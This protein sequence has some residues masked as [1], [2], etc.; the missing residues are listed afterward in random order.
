[1][2]PMKSSPKIL[3]ALSFISIA[4]SIALYLA[5]LKHGELRQEI[6]EL[7]KQEQKLDANIANQKKEN[8]KN[9]I[10]IT[11]LKDQV[12]I[13]ETETQKA[14]RSLAIAKR[15]P[16]PVEIKTHHEALDSI[17]EF[18]DDSTA[19]Y[20]NDHFEICSGTVLKMT[21]DAVNWR[22]NKPIYENLLKE[23]SN[24]ILTLER[25]TSD[26]SKLIGQQDI[27][28]KGLESKEL[29][30]VQVE[31]NLKKQLKLEKRKTLI[32]IGEAALIGALF[33]WAAERSRR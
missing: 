31:A 29:M 20:I 19:K 3:T 25:E 33:T 22:I 8:E 12:L 23:H 17:K 9:K 27:L 2:L 5:V 21:G 1:M 18:Y 26:K 32:K 14:K 16:K 10:E 6:K 24:V 15:P 7:K 30:H 28:I 11:K 4:G 13:A